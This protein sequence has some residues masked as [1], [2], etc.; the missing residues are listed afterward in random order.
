MTQ[1]RDDIAKI[2]IMAGGKSVSRSK[3]TKAVV[4]T[5]R[6]C[7][8]LMPFAKKYRQVFEHGI[9]P[10][11]QKAGFQC[12]RADHPVGPQNIVRDIIKSIFTADVIVADISEAN[13]NVFYELGVAHSIPKKTTILICDKQ[14]SK[15]PFDLA[16]YRTI[17]YDNNIDGIR[18][19]L[20][21]K[22]ERAFKKFDE[23]VIGPTNP[24]QDFLPPEREP[25]VLERIKLQQQ[26]ETLKSKLNHVSSS[27]DALLISD[28]Q[29]APHLWEGFYGTYYAWN[30]SWQTECATNPEAWMDIHIKRYKDKRLNRAVYIIGGDEHNG[31]DDLRYFYVRGLQEF[32]KE[33]LKRDASI[34]SSLA[35]KME[36]YLVKKLLSNLTFF[37]G[38]R[39]N[40]SKKCGLLLINEEPFLHSG[41]PTVAFE[42]RNEQ[43]ITEMMVLCDGIIAT[44]KKSTVGE[45]LN[46]KF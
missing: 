25:L 44:T 21:K 3:K 11:A 10:V 26:I 24:V 31:S 20:R 6:T 41:A 32:L 4:K 19:V 8:V 40:E 17:F 35:Q 27:S 2:E 16:S 38:K 46:M 36:I 43:I 22:L 5:L 28:I 12:I 42:T 34:K 33:I 9:K 15:L 39:E 23:S 18:K 29:K 13:P 37:I 7:F 1:S 30:P 45:I 14:N